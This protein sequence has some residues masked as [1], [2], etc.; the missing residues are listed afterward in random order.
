VRPTVLLLHAFPLDS[1]LWNGHREALEEAGWPVVAPDLPGEPSSS[2]REWAQRVLRIVEGDFVPVGVSMGGFLAFELW[3]QAPERI[4]AMV[5]CDTR[6]VPEPEEGRAG[7]E[8]MIRLAAEQ[9]LDAVWEAMR[10]RLMAAGADP[11]AV[12]RARAIAVSQ[13][14]SG[15]VATIEA[16]RDR[17]DSRPTLPTI[18]VPVLYVVGE[19]DALTGPE[20][21]EAMARETPGAR[22]VR[23]AGCGHLPPIER[24]G[25]FRAALLGFLEEAAA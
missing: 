19:E 5:L 4:R 14:V 3:R 20:V 22:L 23:I 7:R 11:G 10:P 25:E 13:P 12:A 21:A 6:A 9:G 15:I 16:I 18:S 17:E 24:P 8:G 1:R 2:F